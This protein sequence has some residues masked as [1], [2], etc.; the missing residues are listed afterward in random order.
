MMTGPIERLPRHHVDFR[1]EQSLP[2]AWVL[3][4]GATGAVVD[5][6]W[7]SQGTVP[8]LQAGEQPVLAMLGRDPRAAEAVVVEAARS[9]RRT[10]V[11]VGTGWAGGS[12]AKQLAKAPRVLLRR[13][14]EVPASAIHTDGDARVW[15]GG[16]TALHL[17]VAQARSLRQTFLRLFWHDAAEES[18]S[19]ESKLVWRVAK[20]RPFDVPEVASS[21]PCRIVEPDTRLPSA[22]AQGVLHLMAGSP[23]ERPLRRLW[24]PAGPDHHNRL[25]ALRAAG[26]IIR[27]HARE[28]PDIL[29]EPSSGELLLP[30][31]RGR[32]RVALTS[33]QCRDILV[34]LEQDAPWTF[35]TR[36]RLG[37]IAHRQ[38]QFWLP[39]EP[40]ARGL[41]A[42]QSL[43]LADLHADTLRAVPSTV[44]PSWPQADPLALAARYEWTVIPPIPP[45]GSTTDPLTGAWGQVDRD[46]KTRV[47]TL[48]STL[49]ATDGAR[50]RIGRVFSRL[51]GAMMGFQR[52]QRGLLTRV[53]TLATRRPSEA[54]PAGASDLLRQLAEVEE[55]ARTLAN[56]LEE[57]ERKA[58]EDQ[59]R[60]KQRAAWQDRVDSAKRDLPIRQKALS[61][62]EA[63]RAEVGEQLGTTQEELKTADKA[64]KKDLKARQRKLS[65]D[66]QR[67]NRSIK[68]LK[69]EVEALEL[70]AAESFAFRPPTNLTRRASSGGICDRISRE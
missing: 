39:G 62:A 44:P 40:T 6:H 5:G 52:T 16:G 56:D 9:G 11:L 61:S 7:L 27:W 22:S 53:E 3:Q 28:L 45:V 43:P 60:E 19:G 47:Q 21:A 30:G 64:A 67:A 46:W 1:Q 37:D 65:D 25:A 35:H 63:V 14:P 68:R 18:W 29:L 8:P 24:C 34:L 69:G 57:A 36:L 12:T 32:L 10:Y 51:M 59:E 70:Q 13:V 23:P 50:S 31:S 54:G 4:E 17:D 41:I 55:K 15:L 58:R 49:E 2:T 66:L 20:D 33:E 26:T 48:R 42:E 38:A